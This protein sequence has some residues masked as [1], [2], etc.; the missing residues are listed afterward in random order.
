MS[1]LAA[2]EAPDSAN[3]SDVP[4]SEEEKIYVASQRQLMW[5]RFRKHRVAVGSTAVVLLLY[6]VALACEFLA[7]YDPSAHD[8]KYI[9]APPQRVPLLLC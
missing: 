2:Q 3:G 7:P 1:S 4:G 6:V 8:A 9:Y 5:W